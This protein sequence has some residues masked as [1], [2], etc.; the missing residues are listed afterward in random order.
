MKVGVLS[1]GVFGMGRAEKVCEQNK[2]IEEERILRPAPAW[3]LEKFVSEQI[4]GLVRQVFLPIANPPVRQVVF[5]SLEDET[6][7]GD[8]CRRAGEILAAETAKDV[9]IVVDD[10]LHMVF[11]RNVALKEVGTRVR[12]NLWLVP[13]PENSDNDMS[14]ESL[15]RYLGEM[16]REFEYS[17]VDAPAARGLGL[18]V[19]TGQFADGIIL[20]LS[21]LRTRRAAAR[22]FLEGLSHVRLLGTVLSDREFPIPQRIYRRL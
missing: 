1:A 6:D 4:R 15:H 22:K 5:S 20:V 9:A 11:D 12:M 21:A 14:A 3:N 10:R 19:A 18:A 16:R 17:I 2:A 8:I 13:F 7:T